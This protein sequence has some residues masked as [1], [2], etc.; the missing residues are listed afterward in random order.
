MVNADSFAAV[1]EITHVA[2]T[3]MSYVAISGEPELPESVGSGTS[4]L[5]LHFTLSP[6]IRLTAQPGKPAL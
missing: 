6:G 2:A 1:T 3:S 5:S 4:A